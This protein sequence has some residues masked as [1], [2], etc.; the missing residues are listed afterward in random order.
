MCTYSIVPYNEPKSFYA[1]YTT[2]S[3]TIKHSYILIKPR[4]IWLRQNE[5]YTF[6]IRASNDNFE[7]IVFRALRAANKSSRQIIQARSKMY[8]STIFVHSR[9]RNNTRKFLGDDRESAKGK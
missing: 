3:T 4:G 2:K 9:S 6:F 1:I 7:R 5:S 8:G